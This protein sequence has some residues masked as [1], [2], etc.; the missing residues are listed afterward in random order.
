MPVIVIEQHQ[1]ITTNADPGSSTSAPAPPTTAR[2][3][4]FEGTA[5]GLV[6]E[7]STL[8]GEHL[9]AYVSSGA[10]ARAPR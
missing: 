2:R 5:A 6:A 7:R 9:A 3:I 8:T 10:E 1:A 4:V